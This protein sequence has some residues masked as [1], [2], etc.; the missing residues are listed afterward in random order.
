MCSKQYGSAIGALC[1]GRFSAL[2]G[3]VA[4]RGL[5]ASKFA[6][7]APGQR[8]HCDVRDVRDVRALALLVVPARR[9]K[10]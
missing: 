7:W 10:W 3:R 4:G 6:D 1:L 8:L 2:L 9:S 5:L